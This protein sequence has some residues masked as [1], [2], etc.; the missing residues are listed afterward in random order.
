[1]M[2]TD[3]YLHDDTNQAIVKS[4]TVISL[5]TLSSRILG[6]VRDI[7]IAKLLGTALQKSP[8]ST[9]CY[10]FRRQVEDFLKAYGRQIWGKAFSHLEAVRI[11]HRSAG[12]RE[13]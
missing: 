4:T 1:M 7:I 10:L 9:A 6:F 11:F 8:K 5:G 13:P 3:K 12:I 2:S